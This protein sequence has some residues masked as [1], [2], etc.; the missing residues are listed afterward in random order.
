MQ[1]GSDRIL[2]AMKRGYTAVEY[3]ERAARIRNAVPE[4][5]LTTDIIVGFPGETEEDFQQTMRIV[6]EVRFDGVFGFM[7]SPRKF[8]VAAELEDDVPLEVKKRR[9]AELFA[10]TEQ[11]RTARMA[12]YEGRTVQVLVEGP[13]RQTAG[14]EVQLTG[15]TRTNLPVNFPVENLGFGAWRFV[16]QL[17][18]V[19]VE[20]VLPHSLYGKVR[21]AL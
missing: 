4:L 12:T 5:H 21:M 11:H 7:Y 10:M 6:E 18:D 16:G 19:E 17:V 1:S 13:A 3:L 8:T 9:L 14:R 2:E 15:R 20:R